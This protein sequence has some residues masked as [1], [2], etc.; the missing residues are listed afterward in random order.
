MSFPVFD[1]HCDTASVL[2]GRNFRGE[3]KLYKN[4]GHIDLERA[5]KLPGY[6]QCFACFTTDWKNLPANVS[7]EDIFE[8]QLSVILREFSENHHCI[9]Q[10]FSVEDVEKNRQAG[11]MSGIL[12]IEGP[13]GFGCQPEMLEELYR[14][15][16][17]ITSLGWNEKNALTGSHITGGGLTDLGREFVKEAQRVGMLIDVSHISDEGFWDIMDITQA[18]VIATHSNSRA[19]WNSSRNL[20]DEMFLEICRTGGVAGFNQYAEFVGERPSLNTACDHILHFLEMDPEGKSIALGGDLDG[21]DVLVDGFEDV[22][23][24]PKLAESL[25]GRGVG[26][27]IVSNI[28]WNNALGVIGRAVRNN[29]K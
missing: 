5:N 4:S 20:T 8:Q 22:S 18:P 25:L 10:A 7:V 24:Y 26:N 11:L 1:L 6:A 15:G 27:E 21:C 12:T 19:V 2:T 13:V 23:D 17:R 9:R 29:K 28:F 14:I 16:F 3:G